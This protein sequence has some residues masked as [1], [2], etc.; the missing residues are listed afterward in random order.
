MDVSGSSVTSGWAGDSEMGEEEEGPSSVAGL[1]VETSGTLTGSSV[2]T[3]ASSV[4]DV[5]PGV[6]TWTTRGASVSVSSVLGEGPA[7]EE[8]AAS[9]T[10]V[11]SPSSGLSVL[12]EGTAV[13]S[14]WD[15]LG[16][17]VTPPLSSPP[18]T[19]LPVVSWSSGD[20]GTTEEMVVGCSVPLPVVDP[21]SK[22]G[23]HCVGSDLG[24]CWQLSANI[25]SGWAQSCTAQTMSPCM[26]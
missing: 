22:V 21:H 9:G 10:S 12:G 19:G 15:V 23:Q 17:D 7:V 3:S 4:S 13:A 11:S 26:Q 20:C 16:D 2:S 18:S 14:V 8:D 5:V 1:A 6:D 24:I 25:S